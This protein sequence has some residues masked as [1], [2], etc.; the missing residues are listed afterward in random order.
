MNIENSGDYRD[1]IFWRILMNIRRDTYNE[2]T[3]QDVYYSQ[4]NILLSNL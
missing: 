4:G 3:H 2:G 1:M